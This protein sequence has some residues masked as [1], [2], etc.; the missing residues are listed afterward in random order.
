MQKNFEKSLDSAISVNFSDLPQGVG[1]GTPTQYCD[2]CFKASN[3]TSTQNNKD[4]TKCIYLNISSTYVIWIIT[5]NVLRQ[6][7]IFLIV[8][9]FKAIKYI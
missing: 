6:E 5:N 3:Y 9:F 8:A 2:L 1:S 4:L 7:L